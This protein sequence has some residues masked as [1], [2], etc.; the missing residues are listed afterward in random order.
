MHAPALQPPATV[1]GTLGFVTQIPVPCIALEPNGDTP[2]EGKA[3]EE[4]LS[5]YKH[6]FSATIGEE[7]HRKYRLLA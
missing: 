5:R 2:L 6:P 3:L 7:A 4:V 1:C